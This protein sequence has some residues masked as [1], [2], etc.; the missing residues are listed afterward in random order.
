MIINYLKI[1]TIKEIDFK[2]N[3]IEESSIFAI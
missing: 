2:E 3:I 1:P